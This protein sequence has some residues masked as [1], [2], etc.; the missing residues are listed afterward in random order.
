MYL[1][2]LLQALRSWCLKHTLQCSL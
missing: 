1:A 2:K